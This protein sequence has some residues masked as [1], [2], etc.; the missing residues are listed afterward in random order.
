MR[1][2][3]TGPALLAL[4]RDVLLNDLLP[5]LPPET[6]LDARLVANAMA[7]AEREAV[8]DDEAGE[9]IV[10]DLEALYRDAVRTHQALRAGSPLSRIAGE[11][12]ERSEA[13]EGV[14]DLLRHFAQD[15]RVG[16]FNTSEPLRREACDVLWQLTIAKLRCANPRFL[17]ANGFS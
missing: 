11:G 6:H 7:V 5:L 8:A 15:L 10:S 14:Q 17:R 4:A 9:G 12:A 3:P 2:L 1:D 13:G 16:A